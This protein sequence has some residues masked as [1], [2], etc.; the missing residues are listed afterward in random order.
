M[1]S[2]QVGGLICGILGLLLFILP[3]DLDSVKPDPSP[4]P[5]SVSTMPHRAFEKQEALWRKH[6]ADAADKL[7]SGELS[8]DAAAFE[9]LASGQEPARKIAFAEMAKYEQ[10]QFQKAGGWS[11]KLHEEILR[12]YNKQ[13]VK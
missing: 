6:I 1:N 8:T 5:L 13:E 11:A 10:E 12:K 9:F 2:K 4:G 7:A 3:S